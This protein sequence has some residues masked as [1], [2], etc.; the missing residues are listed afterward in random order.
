MQLE[1]KACITPVVF[2]VCVFTLEETVTWELFKQYTYFFPDILLNK[3]CSDL[4]AKLPYLSTLIVDNVSTHSANCLDGA[5]NIP[6]LYRRTNREV[7]TQPCDD[8]Y[9]NDNGQQQFAQSV[10]L[11]RSKFEPKTSKWILLV[12]LCS[13]A[14]GIP[15]RSSQNSFRGGVFPQPC[16]EINLHHNF[17]YLLQNTSQLNKN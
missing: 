17:W 2:L 11:L 6:R 5:K 1:G 7:V 4:Q 8:Y 3:R 13:L 16:T 10:Y 14:A 12:I 15:Q 9:F